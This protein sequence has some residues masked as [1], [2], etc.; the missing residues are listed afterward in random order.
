[1]SNG[2]VLN[3]EFDSWLGKMLPKEYGGEGP[4]LEETG[5]QLKLE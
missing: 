5:T 4:G 3:R 1:M 2:G